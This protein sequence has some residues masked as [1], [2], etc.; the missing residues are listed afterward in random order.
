MI[1]QYSKP[2]NEIYNVKT[3]MEIVTSQLTVQGFVWNAPDMGPKYAT[4]HQE[5]LQ[6]LIME[7][8]FKVPMDVTDGID[9]A[10]EGLVAMLEGRNFGKAILKI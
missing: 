10:G 8:S 2:G 7:G 1:S 4:R 6:R 3:L 9:N 5:H